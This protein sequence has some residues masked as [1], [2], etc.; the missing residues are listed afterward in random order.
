MAENTVVRIVAHIPSDINAILQSIASMQ[1]RPKQ[2]LVCDLLTA[3]AERH[4]S[5]FDNFQAQVAD[6]PEAG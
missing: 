3:Y 6:I 2:D 1:S 4:R 5:T